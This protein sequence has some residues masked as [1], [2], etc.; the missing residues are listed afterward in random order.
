MN[1]KWIAEKIKEKLLELDGLL[2]L[3]CDAGLEVEL[4]EIEITTYSDKTRR[5]MHEVAI[6]KVEKL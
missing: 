3:A 6:S 4:N 2:G 1:E 5:I